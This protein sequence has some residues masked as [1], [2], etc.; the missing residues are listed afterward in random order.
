MYDTRQGVGGTYRLPICCPGRRSS[1]CRG[2]R[3]D[4]PCPCPYPSNCLGRIYEHILGLGG[5]YRLPRCCPRHMEIAWWG[6]G[7][8][9]RGLGGSA[10]GQVAS[11]T[12]DERG[13][14]E[15]E[16]AW[17]AARPAGDRGGRRGAGCLVHTNGQEH[18]KLGISGANPEVM[19]V[20]QY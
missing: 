2:H 18:E 20:K 1:A 5:T 17:R 6:R 9:P 13:S 16:W 12:G 11:S 19:G 10:G 3:G 8:A 4:D 14:R 7:G 15:T